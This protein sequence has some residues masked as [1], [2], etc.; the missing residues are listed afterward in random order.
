[1][2]D[3]L[4]DDHA[5][6]RL[7]GLALARVK[8]ATVKPVATNIVIALLEG[9]SAPDAVAVLAALGV[10]A[11]AMDGHTLRLMTHHDVSRADCERAAQLLGEALAQD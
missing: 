8:G 4:A 3:R 11:I 5:N 10:R 9:R 7:L 6:A 2:T 1:M